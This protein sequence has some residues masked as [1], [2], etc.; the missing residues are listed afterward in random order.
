MKKL[1]VGTYLRPAIYKDLFNEEFHPEM[2][3][4]HDALFKKDK[5]IFFKEKDNSIRGP[6]KMVVPEIFPAI[7]YDNY[8]RLLK[9]KRIFIVD[10]KKYEETF[11]IQ[12][13]IKQANLNDL[14]AFNH[15]N[16]LKINT[17]FYIISE[18]VS[19]PFVI[20]EFTKV[21][22]IRKY[23]NLNQFYVLDDASNIKTINKITTAQVV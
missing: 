16:G 4:D 10:E 2:D 9:Q 23:I 17:L 5:E 11:Q 12:L 18:K 22:D 19:G 20:T 8:L 13:P 21:S 1:K 14:L 3:I 7:E 6:H 15:F